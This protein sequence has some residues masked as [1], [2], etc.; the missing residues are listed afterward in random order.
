[1]LLKNQVRKYDAS[2]GIEY[3]ISYETPDRK[4]ICGFCRL[5]ITNSAGWIEPPTTKNLRQRAKKLA[6][7]S[8]EVGSHFYLFVFIVRPLGPLPIL[9]TAEHVDAARTPHPTPEQ[10]LA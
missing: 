4:T 1:M 5:R 10:L 6:G 8:E 7:D 2:D 9:N 3:F